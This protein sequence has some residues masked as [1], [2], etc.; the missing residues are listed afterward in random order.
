VARADYYSTGLE[1]KH[2]PSRRK[3]HIYDIPEDQSVKNS[4]L[5]HFPIGQV[6]GRS[7]QFYIIRIDYENLTEFETVINFTASVLYDD[8]TLSE[9]AHSVSGSM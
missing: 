7:E 5:S 6:L 1:T 9:Y 8:A 2:I 4:T 3:S